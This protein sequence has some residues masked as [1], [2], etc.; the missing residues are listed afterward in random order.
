MQNRID[1]LFERK[2]KNI[3]SI[4]LTAGYP[5]L[6]DTLPI[7]KILDTTEVDL[8]EIGIPF[9][10]PIA[11]GPII[12]QSSMTALN[13]GTTLK[14]MFEQL[15]D[16]RKIT[17]L[18]ILLMGY[19]N[20]VMQYG[21]EPFYKNCHESG[22]D[23]VILPDLPLDEFDT[24]HKP[25]SEKYNI[26]VALIIS[27]LTP[28]S[29]IKAIDERSSGF[30]YLVSSN[31][32]T[33]NFKTNTINLNESLKHIT[34]LPLKNKILIGFGIKGQKEFSEACEVANG[35]IIGSSFVNLLGNSTDLQKDIPEFISKIKE[36]IKT[37]QS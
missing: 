11:D 31:S 22:I 34:S 4:F 28:V 29:R 25:L 3:L 19:L 7:I 10:D 16:L 15:K 26:K 36:P 2:Q 1:H 23:G 32:T 20:S 14:V 18:P 6:T 5:N 35:A 37:I 21:V 27:P 24:V 17:Q 33:G 12:Q 30:L 8:L 9:S 13:N